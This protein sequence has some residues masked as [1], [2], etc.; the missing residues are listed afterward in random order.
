MPA[1]DLRDLLDDLD[2]ALAEVAALR[3]RLQAAE[4]T[5]RV[6]DAT[7]A[8]ALDRL[9]VQQAALDNLRAL[10]LTSQRE[11]A[12]LAEVAAL[13]AVAEAA[14]D[15]FETDAHTEYC[16]VPILAEQRGKA[17]G[18]PDSDN[19]DEAECDCHAGRARAA[20]RAALRAWEERER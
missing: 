18:R 10:T 7:A 20:L 16:D 3:A 19:W 15:L 17:L 1:E 9:K 13:R 12:L 2:E 5:I 14:R 6:A 8:Q 4:A 11:V